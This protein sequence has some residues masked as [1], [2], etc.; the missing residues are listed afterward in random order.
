MSDQPV[1]RIPVIHAVEALTHAMRVW[2]EES[3]RHCLKTADYAASIARELGLEAEAV[4]HARVGAL[5]HDI[6]KMGVD[7]NVLKKPGALD[8]HEAE[9]VHLHPGMGAAILER[10][11]PQPIV[12]CAAAHHEQPDGRGY[13]HG[14]AEPQIPLVAMICRVADVLDSLTTPQTYRDAM[15]EEE[16]LAELRGGAGSRYSAR[17]VDALLRLIERRELSTAA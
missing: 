16:A 10:M 13:P 14:L 2:D 17:V 6:G 5:L 9:H 15:T 12:D 7:L 11:L 4:E 1:Q 3:F 8:D